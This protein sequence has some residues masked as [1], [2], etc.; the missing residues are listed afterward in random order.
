MYAELMI[1]QS[2]ETWPGCHQ[3]AF[4]QINSVPAVFDR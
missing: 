2:I 3:R 1:D 4:E